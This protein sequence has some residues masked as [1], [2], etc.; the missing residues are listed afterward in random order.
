MVVNIKRQTIVAVRF[1]TLLD[2]MHNMICSDNELWMP[3]PPF[4][5]AIVAA[6]QVV[7]SAVIWSAAQKMQTKG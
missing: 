7:T 6:R 2:S 3:L 5:I 4:L 1:T